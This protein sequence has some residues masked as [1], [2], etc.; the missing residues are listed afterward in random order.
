MPLTGT[1][2]NLFYDASILYVALGADGLSI[3]SV[4]DLYEPE[5]LFAGQGPCYDIIASGSYLYVA[6]GNDGMRILDL[7]DPSNPTE[8]GHFDTPGLT[9]DLQ[10]SGSYIYL[11]EGIGGGSAI[12]VVDVSDPANPVGV[13]HDEIPGI[14]AY[15]FAFLGSTILLAAGEDGL[16][17]GTDCYDTPGVAYDVVVSGSL[18][19]AAD[20]PGGM[21]VFSWSDSSLTEVGYY[22]TQGSAVGIIL[23]GLYSYLADSDSGLIIL[24][25]YGG[26]SS[27]DGSEGRDISLPMSFALSQNYPNPFNPSTT[28]SFDVP[29]DLQSSQPVN[30]AVYDIRGRLVRTL[31]DSEFEPGRYQIH[32]DGRSD[33][34]VRVSSGIYLYRLKAGNETFT[35]KMAVLK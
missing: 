31:A 27:I 15:D 29:G 28:I 30:L 8:V 16:C 25:Y 24:E 1:V 2:E 5:L 10:S 26:P 12:D 23:V 11:L 20:G 32:W 35:R 3:I 4:A 7:S 19:Y 33:S 21:R 6:T 34:G 13:G 9:T 22:D 18:I 17:L 14:T